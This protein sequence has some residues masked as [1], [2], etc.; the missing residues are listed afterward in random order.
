MSTNSSLGLSQYTKQTLPSARL[1]PRWEFTPQ[2]PQ[3]AID[4][5]ERGVLFVFC[6]LLGILLK[7]S[8]KVT[9]HP[10]SRS[11]PGLRT[12]YARAHARLAHEDWGCDLHPGCL[13]LKPLDLFRAL[14]QA[15]DQDAAEIAANQKLSSCVWRNV[16]QVLHSQAEHN[17]G[18]LLHTWYVRQDHDLINYRWRVLRSCSNMAVS[19]HLCWSQA[20]AKYTNEHLSSD[21]IS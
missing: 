18:R 14:G 4:R 21:Q 8:G 15:H 3:S 19:I 10:P 2:R 11:L 20:A 1:L 12:P 5:Q 17:S 7:S 13:A 6:H 9:R 16:C